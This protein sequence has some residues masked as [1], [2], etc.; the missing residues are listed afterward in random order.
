MGV[1]YYGPETPGPASDPWEHSAVPLH[2]VDLGYATT[3]PTAKEP[4]SSK[5]LLF[6]LVAVLV[7]VLCGGG[8]TALY[9]IGTR[10]TTDAGSP[11]PSASVTVDPNAII[12]GQCMVNEGT[13]D[14]PKIR[15]VTCTAGTLKVLSKISGTSDEERCRSVAGANRVYYYNAPD[16]TKSF[17]LCLQVVS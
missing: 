16:P 10:T 17:L 11:G 5:V 3:P 8:V 13:N 6:V 2:D 7:V 12:A 15:I 14:Q 1:S 9:L 4:A